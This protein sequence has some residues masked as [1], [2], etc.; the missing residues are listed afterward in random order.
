MLLP[1]STSTELFHKVILPNKTS[2]IEFLYKRLKFS[3][4]NTFGEYVTAKA[5]MHDSMI[6]IFD[7]R[8]NKII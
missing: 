1:V 6:V 4:I 7:G 8:Q 5:G 2:D 3:G